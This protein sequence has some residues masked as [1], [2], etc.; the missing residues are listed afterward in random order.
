MSDP[1]HLLEARAHHNITVAQQ[2]VV[3]EQSLFLV[4]FSDA[5]RA[6][7]QYVWITT[8]SHIALIISA[9]E[10]SADAGVSRSSLTIE[11]D[12]RYACRI[13]VR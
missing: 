10:S 12:T 6:C 5:Q 7:V 2:N 11:V 9:G 3:T 13:A 8:M 4:C 1:P